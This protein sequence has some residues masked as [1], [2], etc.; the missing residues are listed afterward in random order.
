[1]G[2]KGITEEL[3][4]MNLAHTGLGVTMK[5]SAADFGVVVYHCCCNKVLEVFTTGRAETN[6]LIV[7][8]VLHNNC[9]WLFES[10]SWGAKEMHRQH[11][12]YYHE[13]ICKTVMFPKPC[14]VNLFF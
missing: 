1:M 11:N 5:I 7:L 2:G 6:V 12:P 14:L 8:I 4:E 13:L 10:S 9:L 3:E